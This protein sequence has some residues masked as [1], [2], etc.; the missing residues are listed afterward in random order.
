MIF[1]QTQQY[2][3]VQD[4]AIRIGDQDI[5][6][7]ANCHFGKIAAGQHL[8]ELS[9]IR[10]RDFNLSFHGNITK[11]RV[12]YKIPEVLFRVAKI[13]RDIHVVIDGKTLRTPSDGGVK[14]RGFTDLSAEAKII[15][16]CHLA[17]SEQLA[18][19]PKKS[20]F[21]MRFNLISPQSWS[22]K[23]QE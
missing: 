23:R 13:A 8:C 3:V 20:E 9:G 16:L 17:P 22:D 19:R 21:C 7:L 11:D 5:F 15:C 12:L 4:T 1:R 14:I 2:R 10:S 18:S 6:A